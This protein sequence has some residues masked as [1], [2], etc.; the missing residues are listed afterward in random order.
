MSEKLKRVRGSG[1]VFRD[2]G[3]DKAQ[4]DNLKLRS[5]LMMRIEDFYRKSGMTQAQAAK[6]LGLTQ[7]R[8]NALLK[9]RI[10]LFSLDALVNI[11]SR[12]GLDARLVVKKAA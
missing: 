6:V 11:A 4:A 12:A 5:E 3:F 1:N 10:G 8:L 9:G 2:L 7:P